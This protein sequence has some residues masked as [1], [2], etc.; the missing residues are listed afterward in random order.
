MKG[1]CGWSGHGLASWF[2]DRPMLGQAMPICVVIHIHSKQNNIM[3][4]QNCY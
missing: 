4:F 3:H 1:E 2:R